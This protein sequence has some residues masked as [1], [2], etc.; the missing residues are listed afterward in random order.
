MPPGAARLLGAID[1]QLAYPKNMGKVLLAL[2]PPP[3]LLYDQTSRNV[4]FDLL[5][6]ESANLLA[7]LLGASP[8]ADTYE[9]LKATKFSTAKQKEQLLKFFGVGL[10]D[11]EEV[12]PTPNETIVEP[13]YALFPHQINAL[14]R[15]RQK[16]NAD[17]YRVLLHMP[18]G[19]GKTRT[20]MNLIADHLRERSSGVV[21]WLAHSE[22]LCQQAASE[23]EA[24]WRVLGNRKLRLARYWGSHSSDL[25]DFRDGVVIAGLSKA[26]ARLK[27]DSKDFI[28]LAGRDPLVVMDEAH[29]AIAP[30]YQQLL[31]LLVR[32]TTG[33]RLLGLSA[34]PGRSWSDVE[35]DE[36]LSNFFARAKVTLQVD[37]YDNPIS[38]L[39]AE[40]FLASPVFRRIRA[41]AN[42]EL[43]YREQCLVRDTFDLP[44][45]VLERLGRDEGRNLLVIHEIERLLQR[46]KRVIVF[47][48]SV[49]QSGL[50]AAVLSARGHCASTVSSL[51]GVT[52]RKRAIEDYLRDDELPRVLCNFGVLTTGFDAPRTSAALVARPTLS[53][54][55][56]SQMIGRAMRGPKAGG[57]SQAEIVTVV[58]PSIKGFDSV[59]SAFSNWEDVWKD[60]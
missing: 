27:A 30:T 40:G 16:L 8:S 14:L 46:H 33:A 28:A 39:I 25:A 48:S 21:V 15:V 47:A 17:P 18:T 12:D 22:E 10:P 3:V 36:K 41:D 59:E 1:Q 52:E 53:L 51:S 45:S 37:G 57:N 13:S 42:I 49:E 20:A 2:T 31:E 19:S 56:Y 60:N 23:F 4:L 24:A 35:Q 9:F 55:L 58:D 32:P 50:L 44:A 6:P 7:S 34:T 54:V 26:F 38:F 29:Q 11:V 43:T 5:P